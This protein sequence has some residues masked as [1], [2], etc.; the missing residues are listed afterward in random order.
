MKKLKNKKILMFLFVFLLAFPMGALSSHYLLYKAP[1]EEMV[2]QGGIIRLKLNGPSILIN[3]THIPVGLSSVEIDING[4]LVIT[5]DAQTS[6]LVSIDVSLDED[7]TSRGIS[8]G[9]SGGG[10][11]THIHF[12]NRD[13]EKL[14]LNNRKHYAQISGPYTNLF[15]SY[16]GIQNDY[17]SQF[18]SQD[19][20]TLPNDLLEPPIGAEET[21]Q[22]D[23]SKD[24]TNQKNPTQIK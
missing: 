15:I 1:I 7:L 8:C 5:R 3:K 10:Y 21:G 24:T 13:G 18:L 22:T 6:S 16:I 19:L 14:N 17:V 20:E 23:N 9:V 12:Y 2:L 4:N 11:K